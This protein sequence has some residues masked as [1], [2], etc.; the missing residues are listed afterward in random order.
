[1]TGGKEIPEIVFSVEME[2][3]TYSYTRDR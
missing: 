3:L 2:L 1:M